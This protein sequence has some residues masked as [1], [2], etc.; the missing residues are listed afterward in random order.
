MS[1][2][3]NG[4]TAGRDDESLTP[5]GPAEAL[6]VVAEQRARAV[7]QLDVD[8]GPLYLWW[9]TATLLGYAALY[10]GASKG[11]EPTI[12]PTVSG[13]T[14]AGLLVAAAA[15]T[16][17]H[18]YSRVRGIRGPSA[19]QGAM[20]SLSWVLGFAATSGI[21]SGLLRA[22]MSDELADLY[23][24]AAAGLIVGLLYLAGGSLWLDRSMYA[25]GAWLIAVFTAATLVGLP[26]GYLMAGGL[27]G[28]AFLFAGL[29]LR[30]RQRGREASA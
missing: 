12:S 2:I 28:G 4:S 18:I 17:A 25:L 29:W 22:G 30:T 9:G 16:A 8:S 24:F 21:G 13:A 7:R 11:Q 20:Y 19:T 27:G 1:G 26:L 15:V 6:A 14:F 23:F 3:P 10:L 5:T